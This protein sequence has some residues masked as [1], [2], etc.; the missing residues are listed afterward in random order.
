MLFSKR[1]R[2]LRKKK[3]ITQTE[4]GRL[5]N[6]T[7]VSICGYE[8]GTR[9]PTLGT[10][11]DLADVFQVDVNYLLGYDN[12]VI[13]DNSEENYIRVADDE[14]ELIKELR[15]HAELYNKLI[16]DPKRIAKFLEKKLR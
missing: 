9:M 2:E 1:L 3:N 15:N 8:K 12:Y 10:L 5:I 4:L 7:K 6:V 14:I 16:E 11:M 13:S